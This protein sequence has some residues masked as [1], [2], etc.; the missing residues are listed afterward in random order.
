L[1]GFGKVTPSEAQQILMGLNE[2]ARFGSNATLP[3]AVYNDAARDVRQA[4][5]AAVEGTKGEGYAAARRAYGAL[6]EIERDVGLAVGRSLKNPENKTFWSKLAGVGA[7]ADLLH[8]NVLQGGGLKLAG[9]IQQ[10]LASPNRAV[11][12]L[13]ELADTGHGSGGRE[14]LGRMLNAATPAAAGVAGDAS[15]RMIAP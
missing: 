6:K 1:A 8:G 4:L 7:V 11:Q 10:Y 13:F 12:R 9:A 3:A 5:N 2:R 14:A 15:A